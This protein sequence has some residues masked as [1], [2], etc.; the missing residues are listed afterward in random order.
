MNNTQIVQPKTEP[1]TLPPPLAQHQEPSQQSNNFQTFK[2][3]HTISKIS[4][5]DIQ[6]KLQK[7]EYYY[8]VNHV[9]VGGPIT[10]TKWS[11]IPLTFTEVDIKLVSFPHTYAMVITTHIEKWVVTRVLI[12][13]GNPAEISFLSAFNQM[14]FDRK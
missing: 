10:Q 14:G 13:N 6:I 9:V 8:Q 11:H 1:N 4:N 2:T 3:I 7:L 12:D 5:L